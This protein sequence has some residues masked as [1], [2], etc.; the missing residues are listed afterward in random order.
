[1]EQIC[2]KCG[3]PLENGAKFCGSCGEPSSSGGRTVQNQG[4][5]SGNQGNPGGRPG[6]LAGNQG[7]PGG[8]QTG[9]QGVSGGRPGNQGIP[10]GT[11]PG[12]PWNPNSGQPGGYWSP[13]GA[14]PEEPWR[15]PPQY[16]G[17]DRGDNTKVVMLA[18]GCAAVLIVAAVIA[19]LFKDSLF[20]G[21]EKQEFPAAQGTEAISESGS[22]SEKPEEE[23]ETEEDTES[24]EIQA[25]LDGVHNRINI[26]S[27]KLYYADSM[28][29]PF[30]LLEAPLSVYANSTSGEQVFFEAVSDIYFGEYGSFTSEEL[31]RYDGV[32][33][34]VSG[35]VWAE[36]GKVF[37]DVQKLY[38][39]PKETETEE[40]N[41]DYIIPD[42]DSKMLTDADVAGLSLKEINYAK[43]EIYARHGRKFD[44]KELR[45]YFNSKDWYDGRISPADFSERVFNR[46][47][48]KN[49]EFLARKEESM[50]R[51]GYKLDQ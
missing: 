48:K 11:Q 14:Q 34:N 17:R 41:A 43:N 19:F 51:G 25:D 45:D 49:S 30:V 18:I 9:N 13:G 5:M 32:E 4:V 21:K 46:Y 2:R 28:E 1:M 29:T 33:V 38:G 23:T 47:E 44:S 12:T 37:I 22:I 10:G 42:S 35:S 16:G 3:Q 6:N 27:G 8:A 50:Q 15:Q 20:G 39:E 40:K 24:E 36:G 31:L 7:I 26:I